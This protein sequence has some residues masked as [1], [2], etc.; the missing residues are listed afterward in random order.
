MALLGFEKDTWL[1]LT[2]NLI[3]LAILGFFIAAFLAVPAWGVDP[4]FSGMQF[5]ILGTMFVALAVLTYYA[6]KAVEGAETV[7]EEST[8]EPATGE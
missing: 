2:V 3:P 1:D 7:T 5:G 4:V 8:G 6:G